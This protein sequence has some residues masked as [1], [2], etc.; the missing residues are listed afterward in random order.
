MTQSWNKMHQLFSISDWNNDEFPA[1]PVGSHRD[2]RVQTHA[3]QT[4]ATRTHYRLDSVCRSGS[5]TKN[6]IAIAL[7]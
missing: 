2:K 7:H 5:L 1:L 4:L 3:G 6:V